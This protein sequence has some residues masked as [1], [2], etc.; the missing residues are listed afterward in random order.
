M[1]S[2]LWDWLPRGTVDWLGLTGLYLLS[3]F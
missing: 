3:L 1:Q 2:V